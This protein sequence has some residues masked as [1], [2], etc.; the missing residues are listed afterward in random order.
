MSQA[1]LSIISNTVN[2]AEALNRAVWAISA[3]PNLQVTA[4]SRVY[5]ADLK[6][7]KGQETFLCAAIRIETELEPLSLLYACHGIEAAMGR[8][9]VKKQ[10]VAIDI[11][12][13]E[14]EDFESSTKELTIPHKELLNRAHILCPLL[15]LRPDREFKDALQKLNNEDVKVTGEGLYLPL[16]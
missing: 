14:F 6:E 2:K 10:P 13:L 3:V 9:R 15:S 8:T 11:D 7:Y 4:V 5:E 12:I 16:K 1:T